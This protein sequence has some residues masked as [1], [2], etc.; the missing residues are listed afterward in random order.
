M[1]ASNHQSHENVADLAENRRVAR[2]E[3][4]RPASSAALECKGAMLVVRSKRAAV[5]AIMNP[6]NHPLRSQTRNLLARILEVSAALL[7]AAESRM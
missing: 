3:P 2:E 7:L 5:E 4:P 6:T 1:E